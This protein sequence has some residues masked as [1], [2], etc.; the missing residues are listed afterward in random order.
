MLDKNNIYLIGIGG[1]GMSALARYFSSIGK[2]VAGYDKVRTPLC[3]ALE[4]EG[5]PIHYEDNLELIPKTF[6]SKK[7]TAVIYT[8]A[9]PED[10]SELGFFKKKL[11][12][13]LK[14]AEVLG[15]ISKG[16][17]CLAVAGTHGKT[18][19]SALLAHLFQN[20]GKKPVAFVGGISTN[21]NTNFLEG[22]K[23]SLM[24]VEAD[25]FDR[26]FLS[27]KPSGAIITSMDADH[28]DIYGNPQELERTFGEFA[29]SVKDKLAV[30]QGLPLGG[31]KY[32]LET[33]LPY[34]AVNIRVESHH[35]V[36]DFE[37]LKNSIPN[38]KS[39]LP[40]RH[41]IENA[42]AAGALALEYG[43]SAEEVKE[44]IETFKG[45]KRRFEYHIKTEGQVYIDDYAHHPTEITALVNS[46][47]ELYPNK[48][49][50][51]I[52]Q[53]HLYSRTRDFADA[54]AESLSL[55]DELLL[56]PI[57]PARERPISGV[58]SGMLLEK[59]TTSNK[60]LASQQEILTYVK[61]NRPEVILTIGAGDIDTLINPLKM[62]LLNG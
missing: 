11:F 2:S 59:V 41:N 16:Y 17:T 37:T 36:F 34:A 20:A 53:P 15:V 5:I 31:I 29:D 23:E 4:K 3:E 47:K 19:T 14:R 9:I 54:F 8:P 56:M 27:L 57:Y 50:T 52:F 26:S 42:I 58:T 44:G 7:D 1:I 45:V 32:G 39:G 24:I 51:G 60:Q 25:E 40:G 13:L 61:Q 6:K 38:I 62:A 30:K 12:D 49:I 22:T 55:L 43:L 33:D 35:Y 21:Y 10:H 28:L 48:K 46:V 18:T